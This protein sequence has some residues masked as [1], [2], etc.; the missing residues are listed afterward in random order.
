MG[1][2]AGVNT[3]RLLVAGMKVAQENHRLIAN[4]IANADTP[5][6]NPVRLDF[7]ATLND[8]VAGRGAI[9]LRRTDPRHLDASRRSVGTTRLVRSSKNDYNKVDIE[10]EIANLAENRGKY[11]QYA[12]I[13][14][15]QFS[16]VKNMLANER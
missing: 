4:N 7:Q 10:E 14:T 3:T 15:K 11:M 5:G 9:A 12:S 13:L 6:Y 1:A 2:F 8:A 16:M